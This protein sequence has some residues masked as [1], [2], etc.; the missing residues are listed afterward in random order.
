MITVDSTPPSEN[1]SSRPPEKLMPT[2]TKESGGTLGISQTE[3]FVRNKS[4]IYSQGSHPLTFEEFSKGKD[5]GN[6][7]TLEAYFQSYNSIG[8]VI[9]CLPDDCFNTY[10]LYAVLCQHI[11]DPFILIS[12]LSKEGVMHWHMI[13][14]TSKRS[15]NAKR[16]LQT[17]FSSVSTNFS[18]TCQ[19]VRSL[20]HLLKYILKEPLTIGVANSTHFSNY[21]YALYS[22]A[23]IYKKPTN[24]DC[25]PI[26]RELLDTMKKYNEYSY[27]GL[28]KLAPD[29]MLKYLHKPNLEQIVN[30]CKLF[31]LRKKD[32]VNIL[33]RALSGW[34]GGNPFR[35]WLYLT[36]Q[37]VSPGNFFMDMWNILFRT[38]DKINV[39]CLYGPSNTGKTSFVRPLLEIFSFGEI[40]SGGQFMF[41]NYVNKELLIWEEPLIGPDYVEMCKRVFEGMTTQVPIKFKNAQTLYR[42]PIIM[43]TNKYPWHYCQSDKGA[44]LNRMILYEFNKGATY[45]PNFSETFG[46]TCYRSFTKWIRNISEYVSF[47]QPSNS[48]GIESNRPENCSTIP[49]QWQCSDPECELCGIIHYQC[50]NTDQQCNIW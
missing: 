20:K 19:Q 39:L 41:S 14:L 21:V 12:E 44:I 16:L 36:Y 18:I 5:F 48:T 11:K 29:V 15:D 26:I 40:V 13:W 38:T 6:L 8:I 31:Y 23:D 37:G 9:K 42:T 49:T 34:E 30:N 32:V 27:E 43:T 47:C 22:S 24:T 33:E 50:N 28:M 3:G 45:F 2:G 7:N 46:A 4:L 35:I 10:D 17:Y 1:G 25:N